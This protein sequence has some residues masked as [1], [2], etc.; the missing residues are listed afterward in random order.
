M[1]RATIIAPDPLFRIDGK[2]DWENNEI[3]DSMLVK[4]EVP[5]YLHLPHDPV[6]DYERFDP[7]VHL[8]LEEPKIESKEDEIKDPNEEE[9]DQWPFIW[10][11]PIDL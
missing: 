6:P 3:P 8:E 9:V 7:I 5:K 11:W 2:F 4:V 1:K 10:Q